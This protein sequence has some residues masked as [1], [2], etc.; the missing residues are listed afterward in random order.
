MFPVVGEVVVTVM[1]V[2]PATLENVS[3][4]PS[5]SE[6]EMAWSAVD[7]AQPPTLM[8]PT[9]FSTGGCSVVGLTVMVRLFWL[10]KEPS[11]AATVTVY[12]PASPTPGAR[13]RFPVALPVPGFVVVT[14]TNDGPLTLKN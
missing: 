12:V 14:V 3:R 13:W 4:S 5:G 9:G 7:A 11:D 1:N 8:L 2:G 10:F 6:P